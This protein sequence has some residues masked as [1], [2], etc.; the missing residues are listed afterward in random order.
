MTGPARSAPGT[1]R[2]VAEPVAP[3]PAAP[4]APPAAPVAP[5]A[6]RPVM[7]AVARSGA[8]LAGAGREAP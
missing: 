1:T 6:A 8:A 2:S 4:V 3:P 5:P 7:V